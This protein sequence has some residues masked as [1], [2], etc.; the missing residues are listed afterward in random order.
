MI[1][2]IEDGRREAGDRSI[3]D[4]IVKR[5]HD[6]EK[7]VENNQ[8]RWA[9]ELLQNAKDSIAEDDSRTV[10]VQIQLDEESV[11][12]RHNGTHFTDADVVGLISQISSKEVEEGQQTKKT[13]RFGT[14]FLTTHLLSRVIN[15]KGI[16]EAPD[17]SF[18]EFEFLLD[19]RGRTTTQL[20]PRIAD[21]WKHF[22]ESIKEINTDYNKNGFNTSFCYHLETEEQKRIAKIGV[23]EFS[24]L[25]PFVLAFVPKIEKIEIRDNI[26]KSTTSFE[27]RRES[28]DDSIVH[29]SQIKNGKEA[30]ILILCLSNEKV[31]I[32][33]N[34]EKVE[35]GYLIKSIKGFP[36]LFCDFPLIG[37][38][39]FH[40]PV[41]VNSFFFN[42]QTERDGIWLKGI[43]DEV[44]ENQKL[45]ES[46]IELY[47]ELVS[48]IAEEDFFDLHNIVETRVPST[49]S[50]YFDEQWY[51]ASIQE[52]VRDFIYSVKIVELEDDT[53]EKSAI[54][55]LCFPEKDFSEAIREK[56]WGFVFDLA[57]HAVC[58]KAHIHDWCNISWDGWKIVDYRVLVNGLAKQENISKLGLVLR[59][60]EQDTFEWLNSFG[61]FVLNNESNL[62]LFEKTLAIPNQNGAFEKKINLYIDAVQDD[63]LIYVL[64]L[65]GDDW[66]EILLHKNVSFIRE[67]IKEK[68]KSDIAV[69]I[70]ETL[71]RELKKPF[72]ENNENLG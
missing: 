70:T 13:G 44:E 54:K 45:L 63:E 15:I 19:R 31:A 6:L 52:P 66:K 72:Y 37:T 18:Y 7:T 48:K 64:A 50:R 2:S 69:R 62:I 1:Q 30:D 14:G 32:A 5:L 11:E 51:K 22:R 34:V 24:K 42:P 27:N 59:K 71:N 8:G 20:M 17:R 40:F 56:I 9:W 55:D 46:A 41:V 43:D 53:S 36:K 10:S 4:K 26:S 21:S 47:Q 33:S 29:I 39:N 25:I 38:E 28:G 67:H 12:F 16:L 35:K 23:E 49:D 58:R 68:K 3:A 60:N 65:L 57:P 61:E